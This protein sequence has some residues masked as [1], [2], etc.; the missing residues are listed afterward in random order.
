V[1]AAAATTVEAAAGTVAEAAG[2]TTREP[3]PNQLLGRIEEALS[4]AAEVL[5]RFDRGTVDEQRK[6]GGDPVTEADLAVDAQLRQILLADGEGWL[7]EE[8]ADD[9]SRLDKS[10][11]W[12]VDPLDGTREFI[13]GLPEF[14]SSVAAVVDGVPVAGGIVNVAA[15]I[16]VIGATGVG[17]F[18]NGTPVPSLP[19]PPLAD[20]RVLASRSEVRRGQWLVVEADG[21]AVE[22]MGSVAYKLGRVAAGLDHITWTPVPKHEWDVAGGAALIAASGG[23]VLGLDASPLVFNQDH[24]WFSGV[25]GLAR[26]MERHLDWVRALI[27]KQL[28]DQ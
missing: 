15:D 9:I 20:I 28:V 24:P 21:V 5:R 13:D 12:I 27:G 22:P 1:E 7:S 14:C 3:H 26:G 4:A 25:I 16:E 11:V 17:V 23:S 2:T 10:L 6:I 19:G 8:S 18:R